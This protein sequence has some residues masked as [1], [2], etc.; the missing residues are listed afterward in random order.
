MIIAI[1][2]K[3]RVKYAGSTLLYCTAKIMTGF[4]FT[5]EVFIL[6]YIYIYIYIYIGLFFL[7]SNDWLDNLFYLF[8]LIRENAKWNTIYYFGFSSLQKW[9]LHY[10]DALMH[11]I[12][13]SQTMHYCLQLQRCP[14]GVM[15][16]LKFHKRH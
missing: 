10:S 6:K 9:C 5:R 1:L 8:Q 15:I 13:C 12:S 7:C 3:N 4:V 16:G 14:F 2:S 11:N